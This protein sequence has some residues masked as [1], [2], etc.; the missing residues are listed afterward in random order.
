MEKGLL[1]LFTLVF[2]PGLAFWIVLKSKKN[3]LPFV[4]VYG[5]IMIL[6]SCFEHPMCTM[7]YAMAIVGYG[8]YASN[9]FVNGKNGSYSEFN[10]FKEYVDDSGA[11]Y[12][13]L[14]NRI[15]H[16]DEVG[17]KD[18]GYKKNFE[19][20]Y[21]E[22]EESQKKKNFYSDS[23]YGNRY[24]SNQFTEDPRRA[25]NPNYTYRKDYSKSSTAGSSQSNVDEHINHEAVALGLRYFS[26]CMNCEEAKRVYH[27][28]AVK[29]HPDNPV[30]GNQE[31]FV[32]IDQ[33]YNTFMETFK[34]R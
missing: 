17:G 24:R 10:E 21:K 28:Y 1:Q 25:S 33:Q 27:K 12:D 30:T 34:N 2:A 31:K 9:K 7:F 15:F 19:K 22:K 6:V 26:K 29:Y 16:S 20:Y 11:H 3:C 8:I 13:D 14:Y 23:P 5:G 18:N 32:E 4:I